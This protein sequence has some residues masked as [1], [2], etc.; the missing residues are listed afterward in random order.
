MGDNLEVSLYGTRFEAT[1]ADRVGG[2]EE[3]TIVGRH[4]E[5]G[6]L[7]IDGVRLQEPKVGDLIAVPVTGAY[8]LTMANNYNGSCRPPIVFVREGVPRL[9][10]R[11]EVY[12]DFLRRDLN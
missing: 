3:C 10:L 11:R 9:V 12:D 6:D 8:C 7:L 5:S 1:V 2:G 4:C